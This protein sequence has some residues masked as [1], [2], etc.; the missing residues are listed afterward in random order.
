MGAPG[1][2]PAKG[3]FAQLP[4]AAR[5]A[6]HTMGTARRYRAGTVLFHEGDPSDWL[7]L[8]TEGRVKVASVTADGKDVL[9]AL[10]G[11]GELLG[12]L[13]AVDGLPRSATATALEGLEARVISAAEFRGF[14]R[15]NP[16]A[17]VGLL[18]SVCG[19]LRVSDRHRVEFVALDVTGR[20]ARRLIEIAEQFGVPSPDGTICI[21]LGITQDDLAGWTGSS[22]EAAAKALHDLRERGWITTARRTVTVTNL[23][24]LRS[25]AN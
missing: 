2:E 8:V 16:D 15:T 23:E 14:L 6:L 9:L 18:A 21:D 22:R 11:A 20:V 4:A 3:W 17:A 7:L 13:S 25:R 10:C 5:E 19:R 1:P 12:E 24:G